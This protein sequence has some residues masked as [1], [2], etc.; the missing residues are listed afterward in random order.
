MTDH[1][2]TLNPP[3]IPDLIVVDILARVESEPRAFDTTARL[4]D[5]HRFADILLAV[6]AEHVL[7]HSFHELLLI[8]GKIAAGDARNLV[9]VLSQLHRS[10]ARRVGQ[11][12]LLALIR[13]ECLEDLIGTHGQVRE[14]VVLQVALFAVTVNQ[15]P[16][17]CRAWHAVA[18]GTKRQVPTGQLEFK[19]SLGR[20]AKDRD[21]VFGKPAVIVFHLLHQSLVTILG[22]DILDHL[23][24]QVLLALVKEVANRLADNMPVRVDSRAPG[25][26]PGQRDGLLLVRCECRIK[27]TNH[28][29]RS[30]LGCWS[31]MN[32]AATNQHGG[33]RPSQCQPS[34]RCQ[35]STTIDGIIT[36][37][38]WTW[39]C[40]FGHGALSC[41]GASRLM[42]PMQTTGQPSLDC[43]TVYR[44]K[45]QKGK[46]SSWNQEK[47]TPPEQVPEQVKRD[48]AVAQS[49]D[50]I[51]L[52]SSPTLCMTS[53]SR[54]LV[55]HAVPA[56]V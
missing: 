2:G 44:S 30:T 40:F 15:W 17:E 36:I 4:E 37:G 9:N 1:C 48:R 56:M 16:A 21:R 53:C 20:I 6:G 12:G 8:L 35:E 38:T 55:I 47:T 28:G 7:E 43:Q 45:T 10:F 25:I 33:G 34:S 26:I 22:G 31:C 52:K 41:R 51:S 27:F 42:G 5:L 39:I 23:S 46:T 29:F 18:I 32:H 19:R 49:Y 24:D 13:I 50:W 14:E 3:D 54:Y 11:Q